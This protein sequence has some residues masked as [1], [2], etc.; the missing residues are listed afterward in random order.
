MNHQPTNQPTNQ[1][2]LL[3]LCLGWL[4]SLLMVAP[5][6][7]QGSITASAPKVES[8]FADHITYSIALQSDAD[9]T[10]ATVFARYNTGDRSSNTT[11]RGKADITPGKKVTATFTRKLTR[12]DLLPGTDIEYYWQV[13]NAAGQSL[14][15]DTF[16]YIFPDDRFDFKSLS[17]PI[18]KGKLTVYW[19]GADDNYGR[20]RLTVAIAAIEKLQKQIG[21]DLQTEAK[22]IIYRTRNDMLAALPFKGQTADTTLTV[23]GELAGPTTVLLLGGDPNVDNTTYHELSHLVV[24]LATNN[25]LIGGVSIPAWLDEG[26]S[27]FNQQSVESGY[28]DA[29]N[30]AIRSNTL[31]SVRSLSAPAGQSDQVVLFYGEAYSVVK[32]L[33]DTYSKEKMQQLL[34]VFKRGALVDDALKEVYGYNVQELDNRWR[35]SLG[36]QSNA[37]A[38]NTP[39]AQPTTAPNSSAQN[40]PAPQPTPASSAGGSLPFNCACLSGFAFVALFWLIAKK[41]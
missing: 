2:L 27:M 30:R 23:L 25:P 6:L 22:V 26:L 3:H 37:P 34:A 4:I 24:H 19:Y 13:E 12:G 15:T 7:A 11:T 35:A 20:Q 33:V 41:H 9:I 29:L 16:K 28:T 40:T 32:Y 1:R 5:A 36:A 21:V 38:P 8:S 39:S 31:I 17:G 18:G 10:A 14:K